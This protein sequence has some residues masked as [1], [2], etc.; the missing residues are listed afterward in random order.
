MTLGWWITAMRC[1]AYDGHTL[2]G[3]LDQVERLTGQMPATTFVDKG[4]KGH[5]V[6]P[7]RSLVIISGTRKLSKMLK[8]DLPRQ[9]HLLVAR[10]QRQVQFP[11]DHR[12][13]LR[14]SPEFFASCVH[15]KSGGLPYL[16]GV[17]DMRKVP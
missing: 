13:I 4:Y 16:S 8:R 10:V 1:N 3:Q 11:T 5:G 6:D 9:P 17:P 14:C 7:G 15:R 2:E 12:L